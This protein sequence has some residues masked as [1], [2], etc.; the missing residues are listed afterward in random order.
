MEEDIKVLEEMIKANE[1]I[2][3]SGDGTH[4]IDI[5]L[6]KRNQALKH[7]M[8]RNIEFSKVI[9]TKHYIP[10][11]KVKEKIEPVIDSL[12]KDGFVGYA[13]EIRDIL[14]EL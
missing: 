9:N 8:H 11:S 13:D 1:F 6:T 14:E 5:E 10:K 2:L 3:S 7:L 12:E 4:P